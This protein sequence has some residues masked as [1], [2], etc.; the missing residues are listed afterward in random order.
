MGKKSVLLFSLLTLFFLVVSTQST[1]KT[2]SKQETT[3]SELRLPDA[4]D[5]LLEWMTSMKN[6]SQVYR[7]RG[8][9]SQAV[10]VLTECIDGIW[11]KPN[12]NEEFEKLAWIYTNRAYFYNNKFGDYLA[13]KDDYLSAL[14]QFESCEPSS[15]LVAR[16]VY[17][18]LGNIYTRL[19]ENEIAISMLEKFK[20][21]CEQSEETVALMSAY[22]D[23]GKAYL[24]MGKVELGIEWI[25]KGIELDQTDDFSLGLLYSSKA[26]AEVEL[27]DNV[28]GLVSAQKCIQ[29][30]DAFLKS[31]DESDF[32]YNMARQYKASGLS[33]QAHIFS[34]NEEYDLAHELFQ[35]VDKLTQEVYPKG[36]RARAR[37]IAGLGESFNNLG[38]KKKALLLYQQSL[39]SM[40]NDLDS[41]SIA[42]NPRRSDLYADVVLGEVLYQKALIAH[43]LFNDE[44]QLKWLNISVT[45]YLK[46]FEWVEIQRSEQ[47]E[48]KSKLGAA[49]EIHTIG[50]SALN[51]FFDM[52]LV[53]GKSNWVDTSFILMDQTKA[54]VLAEERGFKDLAEKNPEMR[55]ML[56]EQNALKA[57]RA[58]LQ[59]DLDELIENEGVSRL[60]KRLVEIDEQSQLLDQEIRSAFPSYRTEESSKLEG[61][62]FVQFRNKLSKR[63]ASVLSYFVG[64]Q[65]V[66]VITGSPN[67]FA[68]KRFSRDT[69]NTT[70]NSFLNELNA[71][72]ATSPEK[73]SGAGK[74]L[75][76]LLIGDAETKLKSDWVILPDGL[77]N[78]VPFE[79]MV[80][81][82]KGSSFK[83]LNYL[84]RDHVIHYAPSAYFFAHESAG[85]MAKESFLGMAPVFKNS[86]TYD[87]LPKSVEELQTG[88]S[89]FSGE[90]LT[91]DKAT[92][93][94][95]FKKAEQYDILHI[96]THAG[97]NSG[98]NNDAWM[99]FSDEKSSDYK[100]EANE[101]LRLDLPAS[102]VVLNACETGS[103]TVFKGEGPMSL[104]RGFLNAGAES[105]VTNLWSVNHESN[106]AIMR[107]FYESL[108]ET[109]SPSRSLNE[110]K[111]A[112][113]SSGEIDDMSA[114]P[115]YWSAPILIG[116]DSAVNEPASPFPKSFLLIAMGAV[117]AL[118][119]PITMIRRRMNRSA[120]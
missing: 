85:D 75:F 69:L 102:L 90:E 78:G 31:A 29:H 1:K 23:I 18:P 48:F 115:Y 97:T 108:S 16:Y 83:K 50:E 70:A 80:S 87:F 39:A 119:I 106:A 81:S 84:L 15:Y 107:N 113:L 13:A 93:K 12:T 72:S 57:Q 103:G 54:I 98:T 20:L 101:L 33:A 19:G 43:S 59:A 40:F 89:L 110:A 27:G 61:E 6:E 96:S 24:N 8:E 64:D 36:H 76:D 28:S 116:S 11:R 7:D 68:F 22:N 30:V 26:E 95:F 65:F 88:T 52:Y 100:L 105:T 9:N 34:Q 42:A 53:S 71:P 111:L 51:A 82:T 73:Y 4:Q 44:N 117:V 25:S 67:N 32:R 91:D 58:I 49:N 86:K 2:V 37:A 109:R 104:S 47:F 62:D 38:D 10:K 94:Q 77:L 14:K 66:Y 114:H 56:K 112:Y 79:A 92:K 21:S 5:T 120:A 60:K 55:S 17:Q 35:K 45:A 74:L 46:Y 118:V 3:T 63:K 41:S 99:V